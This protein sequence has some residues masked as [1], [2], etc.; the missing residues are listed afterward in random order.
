MS[1]RTWLVALLIPGGCTAQSEES[2]DNAAADPGP[3]L[4]CYVDLL[5]HPRDFVDGTIEVEV[6]LD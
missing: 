3:D 2:R 6:P 4:Q 5:G 1:A